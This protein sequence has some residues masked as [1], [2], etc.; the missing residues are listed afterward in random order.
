MNKKLS[1]TPEILYLVGLVVGNCRTSA[2]WRNG[3]REGVYR[4]LQM[5]MTGLVIKLGPFF[6]FLVPLFSLLL[7]PS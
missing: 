7:E 4:S 3:L 1:L 5:Q 6:F 2:V